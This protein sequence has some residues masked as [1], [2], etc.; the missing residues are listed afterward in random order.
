MP[1]LWG[2]SRKR[3]IKMKTEDL[4]RSL[5]SIYSSNATQTFAENEALREAIKHFKK[6]QKREQDTR[7]QVLFEVVVTDEDID[8]IMVSALEGGVNYWCDTAE[9]AG[10]YLG[11]YA[12]EQISRGGTLILH[13]MEEDRS[14]ELTKAKF[15]QGLRMYLERP[16]AGDFLEVVD[17]ELHLDTGY[18]DAIVADSI[19]QYALFADVIYG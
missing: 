16:S 3:G 1:S 2:K 15:I 10:K 9:V 5:E 8:D 18:A 4:L 19:I 13:D 12:S 11:E 14:Y 7:I 6:V 17:H